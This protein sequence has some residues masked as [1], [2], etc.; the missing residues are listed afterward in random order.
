MK[1][2]KSS[3]KIEEFSLS[4]L[5]GSLLGTFQ[6]AQ[7]PEGSSNDLIRLT[8]KKFHTWASGKAEI[9]SKDIRIQ[10][11]KILEELDPEAAYIYKNFKNII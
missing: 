5:V 3:G 8:V 11:T 2:V 7:K 9:T 1:V 10:I 4:K 6:I